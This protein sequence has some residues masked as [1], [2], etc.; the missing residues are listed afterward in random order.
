MLGNSKS[1]CLWPIIC[2]N[3]FYDIWSKEKS[4]VKPRSF[5]IHSKKQ[6]MMSRIV[7]TL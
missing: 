1:I 4:N 5:F 3:G 2:T 6:K 7:E